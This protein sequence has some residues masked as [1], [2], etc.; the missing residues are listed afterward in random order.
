V[1]P[2]NDA[3]NT[4]YFAVDQLHLT[5]AGAQVGAD[6]MDPTIDALLASL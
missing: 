1:A 3:T 4:T 6:L 2:L 5:I